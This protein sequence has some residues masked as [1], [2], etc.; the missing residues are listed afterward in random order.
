MGLL[1]RSTA[2]LR[3]RNCARHQ[4]A[5]GGGRLGLAAELARA[6]WK[7]ELTRTRL[8]Q[9]RQALTW[10]RSSS[11]QAWGQWPQACISATSFSREHALRV[12]AASEESR[13]DP[14]TGVRGPFPGLAEGEQSCGGRGRGAA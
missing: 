6:L 14:A 4:M 12:M 5:P 13:F 10:S 11:G 8:E 3:R 1:T 9:E 7:A 2:A